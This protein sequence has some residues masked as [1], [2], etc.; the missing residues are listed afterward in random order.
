MPSWLLQTP[1]S[2]SFR[3]SRRS[4]VTLW[5]KTLRRNNSTVAKPGPEL[6]DLSWKRL[7]VPASVAAT[8]RSVFPHIEKPTKTQARL[9]P[10]ILS[11]KDVLLKDQT[12][13]GKSFGLILALLSDFRVWR[14]EHES[15]KK[16][17]NPSVCALVIVP[18]KDLALQLARWIQVIIESKIQAQRPE[19]PTVVQVLAKIPGEPLEERLAALERVTPHILIGTP[20]VLL[21]NYDSLKLHKLNTLIVDEVDY[22]IETVPNLLDKFKREKIRKKIAKYPGPTRQLLNKILEPRMVKADAPNTDRTSAPIRQPQ[23]QHTPQLVLSTATFRGHL[24]RFLF[25]GSGWLTRGDMHLVKINGNTEMSTWLPNVTHSVLV[26]NE[27]AEVRNIEGAIVSHDPLD[28]STEEGETTVQADNEE[29]AFRETITGELSEVGLQGEDVLASEAP[30]LE[31]P[32]PWSLGCI[33]AISICFAMD[34]PQT[35]LLVTPA[36]HPIHKLIKELKGYGVDARPLDM[37]S[38]SAGGDHILNG[39]GTESLVDDKGPILLVSTLANTRGLDLPNLSHVFVMGV[40]EG[41]VD[42]YT[43]IAGRTGRFGKSG[44]IVTIVEKYEEEVDD[45]EGGKKKRVVKD[46]EKKMKGILREMSI[47]PRKVEHF[48]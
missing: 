8:V 41:R 42:S 20:Q 3:I 45:G 21:K 36:T 12:G 10:A 37:L 27:K 19:L 30:G 33:E 13:T 48:D 35:A 29:A 16:P 1:A 46:E 25:Q 14:S 7:G 23:I 17:T 9:I 18:H 22:L 38:S 47:V 44:K 39:K 5:W 24:N 43:H 32:P 26:V 4:Q 31:A 6:A 34:V 15:H 2:S 40:P 28:Q 11:G